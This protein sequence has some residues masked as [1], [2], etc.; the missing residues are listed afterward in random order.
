MGKEH[1]ARCSESEKGEGRG[2]AGRQVGAGACRHA[3]IVFA[4]CSNICATCARHTAAENGTLSYMVLAYMS[5]AYIVMTS[6]QRQ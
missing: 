1:R 2:Y 5:I 3:D 6:L 4:V